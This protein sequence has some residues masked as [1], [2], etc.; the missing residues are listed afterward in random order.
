MSTEPC[1]ACGAAGR[2][3][4]D[5]ILSCSG[6][7]L[8]RLDPFPSDDEI[9]AI[10]GDGYYD[11]WG[12]MEAEAKE[13]VRSMKRAYFRRRLAELGPAGR[14]R[15][16]LDV[17]C[18]TGF[19]LEEAREEGYEPYGVELSAFGAREAGRT[20][21]GRIFQGTLAAAG[22]PD[23]RFDVV[24]LMDLIEHVPDPPEF[25][26][27]VRRVLAPG[28]RL[29]IVTPDQGGLSARGMGRR[30]FHRKREHLYYFTRRSLAAL[31]GRIGFRPRCA[32]GVRKAV[33]LAYLRSQMRIYR[34]P[35]VSPALGF[36]V[37]LL[38]A[39]LARRPLWLPTGEMVFHAEKTEDRKAQT[40]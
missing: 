22:F 36:M 33:T 37:P 26:R 12:M 21:P 14:G 19:L 40:A 13:A 32:F 10:Y 29:L 23:G 28:G 5:G 16:L 8:A 15:A 6:C 7:G 20:F 25:L 34:T 9:R 2:V 1:K 11:A 3:R 27:E 18:A 31:L 38:P 17:G 4:G 24:T 30:W 39:S 35:L